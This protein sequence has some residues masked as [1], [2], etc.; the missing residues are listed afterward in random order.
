MPAGLGGKYMARGLESELIENEIELSIIRS[1]GWAIIEF[2]ASLF[3]KYLHL[4]GP[5]SIITEHDF[6]KHLKEMHSKGYISPLDFQGKRAWRKLVIESDLEEELQDEE[7]IRR[8]IERARKTRAKLRKKRLS[9]HDKLV[10]ESRVIAEEILR[11]LKR[12]VLKGEVTDAEATDVLLKHVKGMRRALADSP[13]DLLEYLRTNL[14]TMTR[15]MEKI[16]RSKGE[17][18][19]LLSLRLIAAG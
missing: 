2:E 19:L 1:F 3:Q 14:P 4:S 18:V 10:T 6:K 11:T 13:S 7:E 8:I 9:P 5:A 15:P 17:D 12:K 16:L